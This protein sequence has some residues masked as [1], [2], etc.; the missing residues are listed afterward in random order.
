MREAMFY[1]KINDR[2]VCHLCPNDCRI[3][4]GETGICGT[5][6]HIDGCLYAINYGKVAAIQ[7]DPIEKKP[8]AKWHPGTEILSIG[9]YG[10]NLHCPFCQNHALV[11]DCRGGRDMTPEE[12][13]QE[14]LRHGLSAIAYTYNEPTVFYEMVLD[15]A[16]LAKKHG[17][18][19]VLV[20]NGYIQQKPLLALLPYI[21][22]M[23]VDIKSYDDNKFFHM[24]GGHLKPVIEMIKTSKAYAHV[25]ITMLLVPEL[26]DDLEKID[27]FCAF[28]ALELGDMPLHLSRYFPRHLHRTQA[29]DVKWMVEVQQTAQKYFNWVTLGNVY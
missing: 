28:L 25:E 21:D 8:L 22:A 18:D 26:Y 19:N 27:R 1:E 29:T 11:A 15:T 23:N 2:M 16:K 17:L 20:T 13:V 14:A 7:I 4:N 6:K 12:V 3:K 5:R 9:S 24:C 10:C